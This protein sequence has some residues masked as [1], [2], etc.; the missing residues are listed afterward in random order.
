MI[1]QKCVV[2]S[3]T[4]YPAELVACIRPWLDDQSLENC[5]HFAINDRTLRGLGNNAAGPDPLQLMSAW[6]H[7]SRLRLGQIAV[8]SNPNGI[9]ALT[10]LLQLLDSR[11]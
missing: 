8:D 4:F 11:T 10:L 2:T 5:Q 7:Q 6:A 9:T 3:N 1:Q